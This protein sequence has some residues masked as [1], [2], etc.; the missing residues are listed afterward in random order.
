MLPVERRKRILELLQSQ[1]VVNAAA[2]AHMFGVNAATIRRDLKYLAEHHG[3]TVTYGGASLFT[4]NAQPVL[5]ENSLKEKEVTNI[6]AK[7]IIARKA[8][9]LIK[10]GESIALNAGSTVR[11]VLDYLP[12]DVKEL[13]VVTLA[14][15]VAS[16][17]AA[18]PY[19]RLFLPGGF[20]RPSSQALTGPSAERALSE[21]HVDRAFLGASA[22][23]MEAGWT[24]PVYA[25]VGTNRAL[26]NCARK[27]YLL[28]DSSKFD[29]VAFARVCSLAEF[30]AFIVDDQ[31]PPHYAEWAKAND[32]EI[33]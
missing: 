5:G 33:I 10:S 1:G 23:D 17:A 20:Y 29:R 13:T 30:D 2:L 22:V 8:A 25:E 21:I 16:A 4:D 32:V 6:E 9:A 31:F 28:C 26:M 27:R 15:N 11:L 18:L 19:V 14:L 12:A 3:V 7:R 24:H